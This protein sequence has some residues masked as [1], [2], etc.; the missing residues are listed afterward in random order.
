MRERP[1]ASSVRVWIRISVRWLPRHSHHRCYR[2]CTL[3]P[4]RHRPTL[5]TRTSIPPKS[6]R[7]RPEPALPLHRAEPQLRL[8]R[9]PRQPAE[10]NWAQADW[11]PASSTRR[12]EAKNARQAGAASGI[13]KPDREGRRGPAQEFAEIRFHPSG[14][15]TPVD[16]PAKKPGSRSRDHVSSKC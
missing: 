7:R 1:A 14:N 13:A 4:S 3:P 16:G 15:A 10:G 2:R 9:F 8:R 12:D 5:L 6:K 11:G